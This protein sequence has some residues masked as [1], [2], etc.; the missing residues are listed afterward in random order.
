[1]RNKPYISKSLSVF[2]LFLLV[3]CSNKG[4]E[5]LGLLKEKANEYALQRKA[6]LAMPPDMYLM[7]PKTEEIPANIK[8]NKKKNKSEETLDDIL[9]TENI[10][11]D[12]KRI[13][14]KKNILDKRNRLVKKILK[15]KAL[16][17]LN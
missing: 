15:A 16:L 14:T 13:V 8:K 1:M 11:S 2:F 5:N 7:P 17:V 6:P 10:S 12:K 4:L 3:S 9:L